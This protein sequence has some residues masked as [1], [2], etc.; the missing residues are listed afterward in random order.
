MDRRHPMILFFA[1]AGSA[2]CQQM[3]RDEIPTHDDFAKIAFQVH[4][5][6]KAKSGAT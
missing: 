1:L 5:M 6:L 2:G 3:R 4:G